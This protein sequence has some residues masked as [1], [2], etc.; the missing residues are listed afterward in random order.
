MLLRHCFP[1]VLKQATNFKNILCFN[2]SRLMIFKMLSFPVIIQYKQMRNFQFN[3]P[4]FFHGILIYFI[5]TDSKFICVDRHLK[6][7]HE[8]SHGFIH[9]Y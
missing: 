6:T 2:W 7:S 9:A 8:L 3:N 1:K 4:I 5:D